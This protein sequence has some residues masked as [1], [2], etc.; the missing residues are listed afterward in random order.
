MDRQKRLRIQFPATFLATF[1]PFSSSSSRKES[2]KKK[3][4]LTV[5]DTFSYHYRVR[6]THTYRSACVSYSQ[7]RKKRVLLSGDRGERKERKNSEKITKRNEGK[8]I[9]QPQEKAH[10]LK[11][12]QMSSPAYT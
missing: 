7:G 5:I 10:S 12:W 4:L 8:C 11:F 3:L 6:L 9:L 1:L 2:Q